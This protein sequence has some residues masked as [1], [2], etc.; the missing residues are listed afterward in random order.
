MTDDIIDADAE[1]PETQ[2]GG[3]EGDCDPIIDA[4]AE[5]RAVTLDEFESE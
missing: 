2:T 4:S 3:E 1:W 5:S